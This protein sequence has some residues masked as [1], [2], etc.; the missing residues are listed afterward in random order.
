MP[1]LKKIWSKWKIIAH[2]IGVFQS[3]VILTI[4]YFILL[5]PVGIIFSLFKDGLNIKSE[6]KSTW[7]LKRKQSQ[8]LE[9]M[10]EQF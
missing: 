7:L 2:R 8:T 6:K 3:R 10:E 4:F 9:E 5:L 1:I